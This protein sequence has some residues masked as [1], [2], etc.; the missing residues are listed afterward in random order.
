MADGVWTNNWRALKNAYLLGGVVREGWSSVRKPDASLV[1]GV[2]YINSPI[3]RTYNTNSYVNGDDVMVIIFG[4][5]TA[6][7]LAT[8][9]SLQAKW[10]T[11]ISRVSVENGE[12]SF[13]DET[14]T[15]SRTYKATIQ[16]T[17]A[18]AV[19]VS[20]WGITVDEH[21]NEVLIYRALLDAPVT[22]RQYE[23]ATLELTVRM[24]LSD[25][26]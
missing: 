26:I 15:V 11:G 2:D 13:N 7:P 8:D 3:S 10:T 25:P 18:T 16:N 6:T 20:E 4:T 24:S 5:G 22:L 17:G 23:S 9:T 19:T 21:A 14:F 1:G 12:L